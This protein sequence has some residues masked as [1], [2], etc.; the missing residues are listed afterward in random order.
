MEN[1][2]SESEIA[3]KL[4]MVLSRSPVRRELV[5][6]LLTG[7]SRKEIAM[8]MRRSQHTI[9]AHL[10]SILGTSQTKKRSG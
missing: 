9:D 4:L 10:K 5:A 2:T 8:V 7:K 1:R 3:S 6:L